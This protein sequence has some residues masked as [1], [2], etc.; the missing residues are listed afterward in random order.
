MF[1]RVGKF[2]KFY[3]VGIRF[4]LVLEST[5]FFCSFALSLQLLNAEFVPA[6]S[7]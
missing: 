3:A 7:V 4:G 1:L 2:F 6:A 5:V